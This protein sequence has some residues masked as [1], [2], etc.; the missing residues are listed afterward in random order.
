MNDNVILDF[1]HAWRRP[2]NSLGL[3]ALDIVVKDAVEHHL[4]SGSLHGDLLG[5]E[6]GVPL[7]GRL[8]CRVY[9]QGYLLRFDYD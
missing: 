7:K 3:L 2:G 9:V 8:D 1:G 5:I 6:K 4:V